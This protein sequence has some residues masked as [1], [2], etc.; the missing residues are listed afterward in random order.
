MND[1][2]HQLRL[3]ETS[4][5]QTAFIHQGVSYCYHR[6]P[7]GCRSSPGIFQLAM[8]LILRGL[9]WRVCLIYLDDVIIF[10]P[11]FQAHVNDVN[12]VLERMEAAGVTVNPTKCSWA[13]KEVKF[14]GHLISVDGVRPMPSKV[15]SIKGFPEPTSVKEVRAFLGKLGE[16]RRFY[17]NF[18][19][20]ANPLFK[21]TSGSNPFV[22]Q[23]KERESF[24]SLKG[25]LQE[26][27]V[28]RFPDYDRPFAVAIG[29]DDVGIDLVLMQKRD[30]ECYQWGQ[31]A[32][33]SRKF[34]PNE[35]KFTTAEQV[36]VGIVTAVEKFKAA[37]YYQPFTVM[38]TSTAV[39]FLLTSTSIEGRVAKWALLLSDKNYTVKVVTLSRLQRYLAISPSQGGVEIASIAEEP[40]SRLP[41]DPSPSGYDIIAGD[42]GITDTLVLTYDGGSRNDGR[43]GHSYILWSVGGDPIAAEGLYDRKRTNNEQEFMGLY[44]GV[45]AGLQFPVKKLV[46]YGDSQWVSNLVN[47][48]STPGRI[49]SEVYRSLVRKALDQFEDWSVIH[50]PRERNRAADWLCGMAI[51]TMGDVI[52]DKAMVDQ[53]KSRNDWNEVV[54][55][56]VTEAQELESILTLNGVETTDLRKHQ[57][58]DPLCHDLIKFVEQGIL[59]DEEKKSAYVKQHGKNFTIVSK[60]LMRD[61]GKKVALQLVVPPK[62]RPVL[63]EAEHAKYWGGHGGSGQLYQRLK[64]RYHWRGMFED[65]VQFVKGCMCKAFLGGKN[66][67]L[68]MQRNIVPRKSL[69]VW[70]CDVLGPFTPSEDGNRFVMVLCC[71]YSRWTEAFAVPN[72]TAETFGRL[73]VDE[74]CCRY[75][76]PRILLTDRGAEFNSALAKCVYRILNTTKL[77]SSGY[78]PQVCGKV[79]RKV[80]DVTKRLRPLINEDLSDWDRW[81]PRVLFGMRCAYHR[82]TGVSP[83]HLLFGCDMRLP[84][85]HI[86]KV[87]EELEFSVPQKH[88]EYCHQLANQLVTV[89]IEASKQMEDMI[90]KDEE[91]LSHFSLPPFVVGHRVWLYCNFSK[92]NLSKKLLRKWHGPYIITG[93]KG[94]VAALRSE[95]GLQMAHRINVERLRPVVHSQFRPSVD[96]SPEAGEL[97]E[98]TEDGGDI[99][100]PPSSYEL[101]TDRAYVEPNSQVE[102][103]SIRGWKRK[104]SK[105]H[106]KGRVEYLVR[107]AGLGAEYDE[108]LTTDQMDCEFLLSEYQLGEKKRGR[109]VGWDRRRARIQSED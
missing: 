96:L 51:D 60:V 18:S 3:D 76:V 44:H 1:G 20:L 71:H 19:S 45:L 22:F 7:M 72:H 16:Y 48:V 81:I 88:R 90:S 27:H 103:E 47:D 64:Q 63:M 21:I 5:R 14:L 95:E 69:D 77:S 37:L 56:A 23:T 42:T 98:S 30:A 50:V 100:F 67:S 40:S 4:K 83:F 85:D 31:I 107:W 29:T 32:H 9:H 57:L 43:C 2:F 70:S 46:I 93:L 106:K 78:H 68:P 39:N 17:P 74:I 99:D 13:M 102:V 6:L 34:R 24:N 33:V 26:G 65:V 12:S 62:Y 94:K 91:R 109:P 79:E 108:W 61:G 92:K 105:N 101:D 73:F 53:L 10:S 8:Q 15:E 66:K 84:S 86:F 80:A 104:K 97:I 55:A 38:T 35:R 75:G 41:S 36:V 28:L 59:P 82:A 58:L 52:M 49:Q 54:V 89:R 11:N 87:F 25:I